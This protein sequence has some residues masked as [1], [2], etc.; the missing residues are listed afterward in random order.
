MTGCRIKQGLLPLFVLVLASYSGLCCSASV[1][2]LTFSSIEQLVE[3]EVAGIVLPQIYQQLDI[4]ITI[5]PLPAKRAE[6]MAQT[7][8]VDGEILRIYSYGTENNNTIRV[9]TPYYQLETMPFV[10]RNSGIVIGD[11][12]DFRHYRVAK[13]RGVKHTNNITQGVKNVYN[14]KNTDN[15]FKLLQENKIDIALTNTIDGLMAIKRLGI[16]NIVAMDKPL[17]TLPLYHYLHKNNRTILPAINQ[18]II[19]LTHSG[20]LAQMISSAEQTIIK[21]NKN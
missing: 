18:Q 14:I 2:P 6:F 11:I 16:D 15:M 4:D 20:K 9:P 3:Q 13:V 19:T 10:L 7:G 21:T 1:P 5:T 17:A 8:E 12:K